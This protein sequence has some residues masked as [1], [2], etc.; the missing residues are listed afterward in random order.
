ML[1]TTLIVAVA[2]VLLTVLAMLIIRNFGSSEK[3]ILYAVESTCAAG[4]GQFIRV[5]SSLLGHPLAGG[6][7]VT[8]L[9][10]GEQIFAAMLKAIRGARETVTFETFIY[11]SG[12]IGDRFADAV[13]ERARAGVKVH[14]LMDWLGSAKIDTDLVARMESA[15]VEVVRYHPVRWYTLDRFNN[16]THRKILVIDGRIGFTGGVG[17]GDKW[18][19][20]AQDEDH[21]RDTHYEIEGPAVAQ[22]QAAFMDNWT[23]TRARV[24]QGDGYFPALESH[25]E[26]VA[27]VIHSSPRGGT[28]SMRLMF[29]LSIASA[30]KSIL[31]GNAYFVPDDLLVESLVRALGRGVRV[32]I[33]VPG[34]VIDTQ[35]VRR[36]SRSRWGPLLKAGARIHEFQPTMYH[37]KLLIVDCVWTS[38]GSTNFDNR[39]FRLNDEANMN[40][41]EHAF[42][43][44]ETEFFEADLRRSREIS[45]A[46]WAGRPW[47]ERLMERAAGL[48]RSQL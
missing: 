2:S 17:I 33:I 35:I 10:N 38:V 21:W 6:N 27:Q 34:D 8:S 48:L 47:T 32:D 44:R 26:T 42:A 40:I 5:M 22:M 41:L 19:G 12:D 15:G 37:T 4:D 14:V 29:L 43:A 39:S 46:E 9:Q 7:H 28:E 16:R 24:L 18:D 30:R 1:T 25:G 13:S 23:T 36:A 45:F 31:I 11:W 20:H 3:K